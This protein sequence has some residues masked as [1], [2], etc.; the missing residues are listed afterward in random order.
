MKI[1]I[2]DDE[3]ISRRLLQGYLSKW[4][5][6]VTVAEDGDAAWKLFNQEEFPVVISDWM[7]PGMDGPELVRRIRQATQSHYVYIILLT[8]RSQKEDVVE[9]MEA[10]ADDFVTKPFDRDELRVRLRAGERLME[11]ERS[12]AERNR[13][14]EGA[15]LALS[16]YEQLTSMGRR[17]L[18][19][20]HEVEE[21]LAGSLS[22]LT[23]LEDL[24][25]GDRALAAAA[26][27]RQDN[28][29]ADLHEALQRLSELREEVQNFRE[30]AEMAAAAPHA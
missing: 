16:Q 25:A 21:V 9:G 10:G 17:A 4:G 23:H 1:L 30:L 22:R 29:V 20:L 15:Q 7:M 11:L 6:T 18:D 13:M 3:A 2:A 24:V 19:M 8:A 27:S 28:A 5:H 26:D 12:L 14:L